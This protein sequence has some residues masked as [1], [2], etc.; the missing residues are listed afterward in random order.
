MRLYTFVLAKEMCLHLLLGM[1]EPPGSLGQTQHHPLLLV[2]A[3]RAS[4][5]VIAMI[6]SSREPSVAS[7]V[8]ARTLLLK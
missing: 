5:V 8:C 6:H 3:T 4:L 7:S 2:L 1:L